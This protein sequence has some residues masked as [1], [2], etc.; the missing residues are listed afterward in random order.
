VN[1][2]D[3]TPVHDLAHAAAQRGAAMAQHMSRDAAVAVLGRRL[4]RENLDAAA[5]PLQPGLV[6]PILL[7]RLRTDEDVQLVAARD[8]RD[9]LE[10]SPAPAADWRK[11][12]VTGDEQD[13]RRHQYARDIAPRRVIIFLS[14]GRC[15]T[16]WLT[17]VISGLYPQMTQIEHEPI[18]PL[19]QPRRFFRRYEDPEAILTVAE[20]RRH[21]DRIRGSRHYVETGW[22]SFP[23][24]PLFARRFAGALRVVHLTRHPAPTALS[25]L[26][27]KSYAGSPRADAYTRLATLG[28]RDPNVFQPQYANRWDALTPYEK[29][30][31]WWT[32]VHAFGL[33]FAT[34]FDQVEILRIRSEE[35]LGGDPATL[36][37]LL[38]FLDL[39]WDERILARAKLPVD[40]WHHRT[41]E[42]DDPGLL[43]RHPFAIETARR[44]GYEAD[45]LPVGAL[46]ERYRGEPDPGLDRFGRFD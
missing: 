25:H 34:R 27:H 4:R 9:Q 11:R 31:F 26:A 33:E 5:E 22:P 41:D 29:C 39:P 6:P 7:E 8:P 28:P 45:R 40:R 43:R 15:G 46:E 17:R 19:Y 21:V 38:D 44:L 35:M 10:L 12:E 20:V 32:E 37:R 18:G 36:E 3:L 1:E 2:V 16:Q 13:A 23:A 24:L 14:A 30:L 42:L